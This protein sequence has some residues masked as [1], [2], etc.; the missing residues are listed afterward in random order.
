MPCPE[1]RKSTGLH[2]ALRPASC[3]ESSLHRFAD[4]QSCDAC[5]TESAQAPE[6]A[7]RQA[8][9]VVLAR[10]VAHT[11]WTALVS[12]GHPEPKQSGGCL[13]VSRGQRYTELEQLWATHITAK[14]T[15][16]SLFVLTALLRSR[17][18]ST[19]TPQLSGC[20]WR[21]RLRLLLLRD[22]PERHALS[23]QSWVLLAAQKQRNKIVQ[24]LSLRNLRVHAQ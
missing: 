19:A 11:S 16:T 2:Q 24:P 13:G 20:A 9:G 6:P 3:G 10:E 15:L 17:K 12:R 21:S 18:Y 14:S 7:R 23:P 8:C 22:D 5:N 1:S 4:F